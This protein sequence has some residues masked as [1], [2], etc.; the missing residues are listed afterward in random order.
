EGSFEDG[1]GDIEP[2]PAFPDSQDLFITLTEIPYQP[3]PPVNPDSES[4]EGSGG[5]CYKQVN[6]YFFKNRNKNYMKRR[7]IHIG[8]EQKSSWK[9]S[10]KLS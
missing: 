2:T 9:S 1:A 7:S 6:I 4:G 5:K 3:S 10:T 8:I